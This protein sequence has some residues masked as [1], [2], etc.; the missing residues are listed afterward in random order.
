MT[1]RQIIEAET[2]KKALRHGPRPP[3][4]EMEQA[5]AASG[6]KQAHDRSWVRPYGAERFVVRPV[7]REMANTG[8]CKW[9]LDHYDT[10]SRIYN[11]RPISRVLLHDVNHLQRFLSI[12]E[13][14]SPKKA[15]TR[16]IKRSRYIRVEVRMH[17]EQQWRV[18]NV[19]VVWKPE[20]VSVG[21]AWLAGISIDPTPRFGLSKDVWEYL[22]ELMGYNIMEGGGDEEQHNDW[23][24]Q[25]GPEV[26]EIEV[27]V[28]DEMTGPIEELRYKYMGDYA[29][30]QEAATYGEL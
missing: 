19:P 8:H 25:F 22:C 28:R 21:S 29:R 5:L 2:P 26:G 4:S 3:A 24:D 6:F 18:E 13:A 23:S 12:Y 17:G 14:E 1:A 10:N 11:T 27:E 15:L 7:T 20:M 30:D 9:Y 16:A